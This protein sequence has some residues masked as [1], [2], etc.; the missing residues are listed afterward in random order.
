MEIVN[1]I[2]EPRPFDDGIKLSLN[3]GVAPLKVAEGCERVP[4]QLL[5]LAP[6]RPELLGE[7]GDA[8]LCPRGFG[9]LEHFPTRRESGSD[10]FI[11]IAA[12]E[13]SIA[14]LTHNSVEARLS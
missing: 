13:A 12:G 10:T 2:G 6:Q 4:L 14:D 8:V 9:R 11:E 1:E 3:L 7:G 5:G